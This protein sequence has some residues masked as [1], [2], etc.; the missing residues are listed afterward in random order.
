MIRRIE[1]LSLNA[2]PALKNMFYDGWIIRVSEGYS[3]RANSVQPIYS[4]SK[5]VVSKIKICEEI[6]NSNNLNTVFKITPHVYPQDLDK[7]LDE[8]GYKKASPT[9]V[10]VVDLDTIEKSCLKN[11]NYISNVTDEWINSFYKLSKKDIATKSIHNRMLDNILQKKFFVS[12]SLN[13]KT[14]ACGLGVLENYFI[15]LFDI[16]VDEQYRNMGYGKHLVQGILQL[17][18]NNGAKKAYLQVEKKNAPALK[19]YSNIGFKEVYDYWYRVA[20]D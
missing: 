5:D 6:Y 10:Q 9:S 2:W 7:L 20:T 15:G 17:G 14:I 8:K 16:V 1:E 13:D 18:K 3:N 11:F 12:M 4:S 19:L